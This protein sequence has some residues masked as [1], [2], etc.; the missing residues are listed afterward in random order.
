MLT[1][2]LLPHRFQKIGWL[3]FLPFSVLLFTNN[4]FDFNFAWLEF[5]IREGSFFED[6][7]ENFT[8]EFALIGTFISL[9]LIAFSREKEEDEYI[10]KLR[11][12]SLLVAFYVNTFILILGTLLF[13]GFGYLEFMGYNMFTIQL[14]FIGRF[15]WV[16]RKQKQSLLAY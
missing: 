15:R 9:F 7:K 8:N 16:L 12:D 2:I 11:L 10:Q 6:S 3:L 14:I 13:Y 5:G 1:K 4:Y